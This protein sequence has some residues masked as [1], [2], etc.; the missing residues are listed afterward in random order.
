MWGDTLFFQN[1]LPFILILIVIFQFLDSRKTR[2]C[3]EKANELALTDPLT[4]V[5]NYR[6]LVFCLD[7]EDQKTKQR[8]SN[9]Y[10]AVLRVDIDDLK[11]VNDDFGHEAG[12]RVLKRFTA[13][14]QQHLRST[15]MMCRT[16]GDEFTIVLRNTLSPAQSRVMI[17]RIRSNDWFVQGVKVHLPSEKY[18][19][20]TAS[21]GFSVYGR[22]GR[23]SETLSEVAGKRER[24]AKDK[25]YKARQQPS[26]TVIA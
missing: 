6:A 22:D 25:K 3:L 16:G 4:G 11:K 14:L 18:C 12:D 15:D 7:E 1:F 17:G 5:Y 26:K 9:Y 20:C 24:R 13:D 8:A 23:D 10:Y 19:I 2:K 21:F